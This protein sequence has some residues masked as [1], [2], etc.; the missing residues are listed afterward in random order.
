MVTP[1]IPAAAISALRQYRQGLLTDLCVIWRYQAP[2]PGYVDDRY[3][4]DTDTTPCRVRFVG[5]NDRLNLSA[6]P[7]LRANIHFGLDVTLAPHDRIQI[8]QVEDLTYETM[9]PIAFEIIGQPMTTK[10]GVQISGRQV[11]M[12][13]Q[14]PG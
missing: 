14:E 12:A 6:V 9:L 4:P 8:T 11:Q 13:S 3:V 5:A 1:M 2:E 10:V 7:E